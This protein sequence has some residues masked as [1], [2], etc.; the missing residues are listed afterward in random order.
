MKR[1]YAIILLVVL[2]IVSPSYFCQ[3]KEVINI[4]N[5]LELFVDNY[6]IDKISGDAELRLHNPV[7]REIVF[8]GDE[9]WEGNLCGYFTVFKDSNIYRMYYMGGE[10]RHESEEKSHKSVPCYA[11]SKDGIHWIKPQLNMYEFDKSKKN[12]IVYKEEVHT[13]VP[14]KDNN[15][16]CLPGEKYKAIGSVKIGEETVLMAYKSSDAIHWSLLSDEPI[17]KEEGAFASQNLAFWD[18]VNNKYRLY[19]RKGRPLS[20]Y[21]DGIRDVKTSESKD[22]INWSKP[23]FLK[24]PGAPDEEIYTNQIIPYFRAPHILLG[25][26]TRYVDRGWVYSTDHLP[27]LEHRKLRSEFSF[28]EGTAVTD[29]LFMSSRDGLVFNRW[30]VAF[31]RPGLGKRNWVYGDNYQNW[32][33]VL[34]KSDIEGAPDEISLYATEDYW[35]V[36]GSKLR[37]FSIRVDGFV[38]VFA[39]LT[40]GELITKPFIFDGEKLIINF[41]TSAGGSMKFEFQDENCKVIP[42]YSME[43]CEEMFGDLLEGVVKWE[44]GIDVS[45]LSGKTVKLRVL[46]KDADLYSIKFSKLKS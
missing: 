22:F 37:R 35:T 1:Y 40:G 9:P 34:T 43:E 7:R 10:L 21:P 29:G 3:N 33:L 18:S 27:M 8:D 24:Y 19:Y 13:F 36:K 6:L 31:I 11:E 12:N 28:R 42:G 41:S 23:V 26:P 39:P 15:P 46:L 44:N 14:F 2:F 45:K 17:M 38:S 32:G 4:G 30:P 25:F 16:S 5:K 20:G